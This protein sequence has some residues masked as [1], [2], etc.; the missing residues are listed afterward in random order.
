MLTNCEFGSLLYQSGQMNSD[1]CVDLF[2]CFLCLLT[3]QFD[4]GA[5]A[6]ST[7]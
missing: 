5:D 6:K 3:C 7:S 2:E 4:F 1:D